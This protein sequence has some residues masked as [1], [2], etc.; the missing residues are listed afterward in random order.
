M[1]N[2]CGHCAY[3]VKDKT[4]PDACPFNLLFWHF[5]DRHRDRFEGNPR[6]AQMYH[7]FD[8]MD[9]ARRDTVLREAAQFLDRKT[10]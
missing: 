8:R 3:K 6:M 2:Y 10:V 9:G 4:G 7:T 5:M 1:P